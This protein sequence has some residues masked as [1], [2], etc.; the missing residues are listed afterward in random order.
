[1]ALSMDQV[2]NDFSPRWSD[3]RN[4][5]ENIRHGGNRQYNR[6]FGYNR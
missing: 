5:E 6:N 3:S 2:K 1:M 4:S